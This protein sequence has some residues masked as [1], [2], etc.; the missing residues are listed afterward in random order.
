[1]GGKGETVGEIVTKGD[2]SGETATAVEA[3][4]TVSSLYSLVLEEKLSV[5]A[6]VAVACV[7]P[8]VD[9][10]RECGSEVEIGISEG[11][12]HRDTL[13][14]DIF[15]V[16]SVHGGVGER[17]HGHY[18][19]LAIDRF[20]LLP[21]LVHDHKLAGPDFVLSIKILVVARDLAHNLPLG[22]A[23]ALVRIGALVNE[24]LVNHTRDGHVR[25]VDRVRA[26]GARIVCHPKK[27]VRNVELCVW[28]GFFL[29]TLQK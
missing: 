16:L 21:R 20:A 26:H 8:G 28:V 1:M 25:L 3:S 6:D 29:T 23:P 13:V 19:L 14:Q 27:K 11:D 9:A 22:G 15:W 18:G 17:R 4:A 2:G 5:T 24:K 10:S 12:T 7:I